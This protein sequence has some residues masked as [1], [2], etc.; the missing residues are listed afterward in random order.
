MTTSDDHLLLAIAIAVIGVTIVADNKREAQII[1]RGF[2][3]DKILFF[4]I[5]I[6]LNW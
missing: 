1:G 6:L 3:H 5:T 2:P 4:I